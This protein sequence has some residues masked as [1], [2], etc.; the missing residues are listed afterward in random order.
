MEVFNILDNNRVSR[1]H[2][3]IRHILEQN[4]FEWE[5]EY[6]VPELIASSGRELAFD[7]MVFDED[8]NIDFAI[9]VNGIQHYEAVDGFGGKKAFKRQKYNDKQKKLYC[10]NNKIPLV[11]VPYH[12]LGIVDIGYILEKA[13]I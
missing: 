6:T 4:G 1:G 11:E 8:E 3:K 12:D 9:E 13:G 7:F 10:F 5:E 2:L